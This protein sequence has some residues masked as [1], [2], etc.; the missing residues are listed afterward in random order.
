MGLGGFGA[1]SLFMLPQIFQYSENKATTQK[2]D[3]GTIDRP[4][5]I[6]FRSVKLNDRGDIIGEWCLD[7]WF[8]NYQ[9]APIDGS[10]RGNFNV[11]DGNRLRV[12]R[13]GSWFSPSHTCR[14]AS[15]TGLFGLFRHD[16]YG[17]RVVCEPQVS[18]TSS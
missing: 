8:D 18:K 7:E 2:I 6:Q 17:L 11:R 15:R 9:G 13:G 1:I 10:A 16:R 5:T 3:M 14:A 12:V 4:T